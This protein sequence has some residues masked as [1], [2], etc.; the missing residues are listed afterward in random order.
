MESLCELL[1]CLTCPA[2][3]EPKLLSFVY[4]SNDDL[5]PQPPIELSGNALDVT[6]IDNSGQILVS[7]DNVH[8]PGSTMTM[9][10]SPSLPRHLLQAF[11]MSIG[12]D[13]LKWDK[14]PRQAADTINDNGT[15]DI[16]TV[17]DK[18]EASKQTGS[19]AESLYGL[20]NLRK[21]E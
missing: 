5:V 9:K 16:T 2:S 18:K 17:D 13:G 1:Q 12:A 6:A 10:S 8:E 19:L 21:K 4:D 11:K 15:T 3:R 7:V 20:T 14:V